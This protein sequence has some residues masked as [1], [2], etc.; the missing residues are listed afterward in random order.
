MSARRV[1]DA[2]TIDDLVLSPNGEAA[3]ARA[4]EAI[5]DG[6]PV[7]LDP[8]DP[9]PEP[10]PVPA[11]VAERR[12][13]HSRAM[14]R[15]FPA[16]SGIRALNRVKKESGRWAPGYPDWCAEVWGDENEADVREFPLRDPEPEIRG[17]MIGGVSA[18]IAPVA[19]FDP[20]CAWEA[21][22]AVAKDIASWME[23]FYEPM[24]ARDLVD[25]TGH[26]DVAVRAALAGL[27]EAGLVARQETDPARP[28][29]QLWLWRRLP[30]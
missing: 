29:K 3:R 7:D 1:E 6:L 19:R 22:D 15:A 20:E 9:E 26:P 28:S 10:E 14:R 5:V 13:R 11:Y 21:R 30:L 16:G 18:T 8:F 4:L 27:H 12:E 17:G 24:T 2:R 25:L 23:A